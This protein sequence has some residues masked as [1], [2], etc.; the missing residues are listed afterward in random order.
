MAL[1]TLWPVVSIS[2]ACIF[3]FLLIII[4]LNMLITLMSDLYK[5]IKA[6]QAVVFLR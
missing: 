4:L 3:N 6:M 5:E 1:T 2:L